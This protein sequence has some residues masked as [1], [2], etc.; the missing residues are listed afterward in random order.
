VCRWFRGK[1]G[2]EDPAKVPTATGKRT[3]EKEN[4]ERVR[5][6]QIENDRIRWL[7]VLFPER[8]DWLDQ[9]LESVFMVC[10]TSTDLLSQRARGAELLSNNEPSFDISL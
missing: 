2:G 8:V 6:H 4:G 1:V 9:A 10:S 3:E 7:G 5:W